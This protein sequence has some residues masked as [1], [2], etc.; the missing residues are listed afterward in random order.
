MCI[1]DRFYAGQY[2]SFRPA[3]LRRLS[4]GSRPSF[5]PS[6]RDAIIL[7]GSVFDLL[8]QEVGRHACDLL[9]SRIR[10]GRPEPALENA[11]GVGIEVIEPAWRE[12]VEGLVSPIPHA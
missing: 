5:P 10:K 1:R 9:V 4:E 8:D 12:H 11:F 2:A 7:G 6:A 3:V